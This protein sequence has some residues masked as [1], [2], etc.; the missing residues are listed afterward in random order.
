[1]QIAKVQRY[2]QGGNG[3]LKLIKVMDFSEKES[4]EYIDIPSK[5]S[6]I[7]HKDDIL[8]ARTGTLG[9]VLTNVEGVF[10]NNTFAIDY[11]NG[12]PVVRIFNVMVNSSEKATMNEG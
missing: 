8:I 4:D 12:I 7:C 2:K 9:L 3:R 6:V 5:R 1:L 10:H 11:V